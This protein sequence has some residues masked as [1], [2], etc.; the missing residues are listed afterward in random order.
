[1]R[2]KGF[3]FAWPLKIVHPVATRIGKLLMPRA[4]GS[5]VYQLGVMLDT[6]FASLASIVGEGGVAALYFSSRLIQLPFAI[7]G[8]ALATASLPKMSREVASGDT[9]K[10]KDTISFGLRV[11]FT[12][13]IPAAIGLMVLAGPM[14]RVL[15]QRGEFSA[16]SAGITTSALFFST[17][18]LFA[19]SGSKI[20]INAFYAMGDTKTT[21]KTAVVGLS[22]NLI[23]N[24]I[25]MWPMKIGGL[26][27]ATSVAAITNFTLL[28]IRMNAR[29]GDFGTKQIL[30]SLARVCSA[31]AIMG[32]FLWISSA[33]ILKFDGASTA[34]N[35]ARLLGLIAVGGLI[36]FVAAYLFKAEVIRKMAG[37][38]RAKLPTP[39]N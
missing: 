12:A 3:R 15:F 26:A 30:V 4:L 28:Y 38:L 24:C 13:M 37:A 23:L 17:F 18:G 29:I 21:V 20:L 7:F 5:A 27:L 32:V 16:Y 1:M 39:N 22:V 25:L 19:Y 14:V 31:A 36:Y 6:I 35:V 11:V 8:V 10:L 9:Q 33:A 2:A 34:M